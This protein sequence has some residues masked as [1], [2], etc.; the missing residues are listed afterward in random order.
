MSREGLE[1][2]PTVELAFVPS[3]GTESLVNCVRGRIVRGD[4]EMIATH[5][6][7]EMMVYS[8]LSSVSPYAGGSPMKLISG[9]IVPRI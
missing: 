1:L 4:A 3:Q 6:I 8:L 2:L 9:T 5:A 7:M